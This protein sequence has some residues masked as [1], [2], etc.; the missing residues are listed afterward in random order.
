MNPV[1]LEFRKLH[2]KHLWLTVSLIL[3]FELLWMLMA[4][5][6]SLNQ[7]ER[8]VP[9]DSAFVIAQVSQIHGIFAPILATVLAS[10][11]AAMEHNSGM[12]PVLFAANQSRTGLFRA[13]FFAIFAATTVATIVGFLVVMGYGSTQ[14]VSANWYLISIFFLGCIFASAAVVSIQLTL[15]LLFTR[16][17]VTLSVGIV[18]G[19]LGSFSGF[20]PA[21]VSI[22]LPWQYVGL[23][24]PVRM[25]VINGHIAG[26]PVVAEI[27]LHLLIV[28]TIGVISVPVCQTIFSR[29]TRG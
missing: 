19:L 12:L 28:A 7:E 4:L 9:H 25:N 29:R 15:A 1:A 27:G 2:R 5:T 21:I 18:G 23:V 17:A 24:T 16:Q 10:R 13:K 26:F 6:I 14:G 3:G 8:I 20:M 11:I 22:F